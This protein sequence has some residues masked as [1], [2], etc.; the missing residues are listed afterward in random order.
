M[1]KDQGV[2]GATASH[3]GEAGD[4]EASSGTQELPT[5]VFGLVL[6]DDPA[7]QLGIEDSDDF[8]T[9]FVALVRHGSFH[10]HTLGSALG[11][12]TD[13]LPD[14]SF[15]KTNVFLQAKYAPGPEISER[16]RKHIQDAL[17]GYE[18]R[19]PVLPGFNKVDA[20]RVRSPDVR[21][22]PLPDL[23]AFGH[24]RD[25]I[26][27]LSS[28]TEVSIRAL[29]NPG[30]VLNELA[31]TGEVARVTNNGKIVG[32]LLPATE[33]DQHLDDLLK[34]GRLRRG[35]PAPIEPIDIDG[36]EKPLSDALS[37]ARDEERT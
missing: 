35:T 28:A 4:H 22:I 34:Q 13:L 21:R 11:A 36:F 25:R 37:E 9:N 23:E 7:G 29:R 15:L 8:P 32:W 20:L 1:A 19:Q 27:E 16:F 5:E 12:S 3:E 31:E 24:L 18:R 33:A 10:H 14:I 26:A 30:K 6:V 17:A 2:P